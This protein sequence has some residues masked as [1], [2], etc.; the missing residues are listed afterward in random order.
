M[1]TQ[2]AAAPPPTLLPSTVV[3]SPWHLPP[4]PHNEREWLKRAIATIKRKGQHSVHCATFVAVFWEHYDRMFAL[5]SNR[6]TGFSCV[7]DTQ[8]PADAGALKSWL[9]KVAHIAR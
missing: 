1:I 2:P 6:D 3:V 8:R 7:I 4:W 9:D 5:V